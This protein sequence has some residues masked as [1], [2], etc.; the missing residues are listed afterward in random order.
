MP[1]ADPL[2]VLR[3]GG[4][5][6]V[7][8]VRLSCPPPPSDESCAA[9]AADDCEHPLWYNEGENCYGACDVAD[10]SDIDRCCSSE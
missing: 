8:A 10:Q 6:R 3:F 5:D 1:T 2:F 9:F 4:A 7:R